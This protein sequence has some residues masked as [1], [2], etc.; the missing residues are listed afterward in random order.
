MQLETSPD[1]TAKGF[2]RN[3]LGTVGTEFVIAILSFITGVLTARLLGPRDQGILSLVTVLPT[4]LTMLTYL[5]LV[6]ANVYF[7]GQ[8]EDSRRAITANSLWFAAGIG[9]ATSAVMIL[10]RGFITQAFFQGM[11]PALFLII[12]CLAPVFLLDTY[13]LAI[14][15]GV[16]RFNLFN[17]RRLLTPLLTLV[18]I[19]VA[20][21]VLG[22]GL[23]GAILVQAAVMIS[24]TTWLV[25]VFNKRVVPLTLKFHL[26]LARDSL[27]YGVKA[28]IQNLSIYLL[29]RADLYLLA[30]FRSAEEVACY[31]IAM[32]LVRMIWYIPDSVGLVLFSRLTRISGSSGRHFTA[33]VCRWTLLVTVGAALTLAVAGGLLIPILY[34]A[35]YLEAVRPMLILL[36]G[37]VVITVYKVVVRDFISRDRQKVPILTA[38]LGLM[39]NLVFNLVLIPEFGINGSALAATLSYSIITGVLLLVFVAESGLRLCEVVLVQRS[40]LMPHVTNFRK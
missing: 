40:D 33:L 28:Y 29:Y 13:L 25:V 37:A 1:W 18:G 26:G 5:G 8:D 14:A 2:R 10:G 17:L 32:S 30:L 35:A 21:G 34:G 24:T 4:T 23:K 19:V 27:I 31:A 12:A 16:E 36:P 11:S 6:Q 39:A 15:Q 7:V 20:V 38:I 22:Q 9:G 3:V